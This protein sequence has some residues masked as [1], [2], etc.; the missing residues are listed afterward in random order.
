MRLNKIIISKK[1]VMTEIFLYKA[2]NNRVR[3][4]KE[5]RKSFNIKLYFNTLTVKVNYR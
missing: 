3:Y 1:L 4:Y 2:R 5:E